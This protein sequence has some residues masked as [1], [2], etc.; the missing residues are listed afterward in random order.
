MIIH[1]GIAALRPVIVS[2][3]QFGDV[4]V[5]MPL[6]SIIL[7]WL[8]L[9]RSYRSAGWWAI[10]VVLCSIAIFVLKL[11]FYQCA[12]IPQLHSPS[13][14]T[15]LSTLIYGAITLVTVAETKGFLQKVMLC[16]GVGLILAIAASRLF[17][18]VHTLAEVGVGL[19]IGA[20]TL[21]LFCRSYRQ[22]GGET[23][24]VI[25]LIAASA[26]LIVV[27]HGRVFDAQTIVQNIAIYLRIYCT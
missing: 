19:A 8:L 27:L 13:G 10:S 24:Q 11:V 12:P 4:A 14:H 2:V 7:I 18:N 9:I 17:L 22:L 25:L 16:A 5:L 1:D 20:A 3:T 6:A 26:T 21:V 23:V 15:S